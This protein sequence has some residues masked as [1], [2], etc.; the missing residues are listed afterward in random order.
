MGDG[1]DYATNFSRGNPAMANN[2]VVQSSFSGSRRERLVPL[3]ASKGVRRIFFVLLILTLLPMWFARPSHV[4][5]ATESCGLVVKIISAPFAAVDSNKPGLEGPRSA[6]LGAQ[7]LNTGGLPVKDVS[8]AFS[9]TGLTLVSNSPSSYYLNDLAPGAS[10]TAYWPVI[11]PATF[12]IS[13]P[14]QIAAS[15][16]DGCGANSSS[17]IKTQSEIGANSSKLLPTGSTKTVTPDI[18]TLG[19]LV[20]VRITGFALGTVGQGPNGTYDAWLQPVGNL[21]FDPSC[22]RLV[23]S[24]VKLASLS[25]T[26]FIDQLYF[27]GLKSYQSNLT[28]YV[29]YTFI[30]LRACSTVLQ[31]YQEAASGTQEKY[32]ADFSA[33]TSRIVVTSTN[34]STLQIAVEPD[35]TNVLGGDEIHYTVTY[36]A[37]DAPVGYPDNGNPVV[38]NAVIPDQTSYLAGSAT[39]TT[40][41]DA[42]YSTNGGSTWTTAEPVDPALVTDLRWVLT[43]P[44]DATPD[45]LQYAVT[46]DTNYT[47]ASIVTTVDSTFFDGSVLSSDSVSVAKAVG[48]SAPDAQDDSVATSRNV[49]VAITV[50]NNDT[51][52]DGNLDVASATLVD[53]PAHGDV[54]VGGNG[55][56]TYTPATDFVGPDSFTYRICDTDSACDTATVVVAVGQEQLRWESSTTYVAFEDLKNVGWSD[57]D[58]NDFIVEIEIRTGLD[59]ADRVA[60]VEINYEAL[61]RGAGYS[62]RFIHDL[63]IEGGGIAMLSVFDSAGGL[64]LQRTTEFDTNTDFTIFDRTADALPP[65]T[66]FFDTNTRTSQPSVVQGRTATLTVFLNNPDANP[67]VALPPAPWDPYLYVYYT[68]QEV[69]LVSPGHMDNTQIVNP[70]RDPSSPL[71]GYDLPLAQTF[72]AGWQW[73]EEFRGIWRGFPEF[74]DAVGSGGTTNQDWWEP[75]NSVPT[76]LWSPSGP[77]AAVADMT[78][79]VANVDTR[80]FAGPVAADLDNDGWSEVIIGNFLANQVEVTNVRGYNVTGWP[81]PVGGG[82]KSAV[83]TADLDGDGNLEILAGAGNGE[84]YAWHGNGQSLTGWPVTLHA[85]YRI[86]AKPA[87]GDLDGDGALEVIVPVSDGKLYAVDRAGNVMPGWPVSIGDVADVYGGQVINSSAVFADVDGDGAGEIIVGSTDKRLYLFNRD[88]SQRWVYPTDDMVLATPAVGDIDPTKPGQEIVVASGD[89]YIY[90]LDAAGNLI[91]RRPTGWI[92]RSS[93]LIAD[94]DSDQS[95]EIIVGSDDDKVWAW[96][97]DGSLVSGWPQATG[98][99]ILSSPVVGDIDGDGRVEI[100]VGSDDAKVWAWHTDG[101]LVDGW[102]RAAN[103]SVKGAPLLVNLDDDAAPE[104]A[105]ADLSGVIHT[106]NI[107]AVSFTMPVYLPAV[108]QAP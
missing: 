61:A 96:H 99:D 102:P 63:P 49:A 93:P 48:N 26:P 73:P 98:A 23:R 74:V 6:M 75:I 97:S 25:P 56:F 52:V 10:V 12:D 37:P 50:T 89:R 77:V 20:T 100:I 19:S 33:A 78:A 81:Q 38:I 27:V 17:Q 104:V 79:D 32:N 85:G 60:A 4:L 2:L 58:Y 86:L 46:V 8:V 40:L 9:S 80:Y 101:A 95:P 82:V 57:W 106:W 64:V 24:E 94:L 53:P 108:F 51:D 55:L 43:E 87:V 42:E 68:Q 29:A 36:V 67:A 14:Y 84:V 30:A 31:P 11:Y 69:H 15:T 90:L 16:P 35:R 39:E 71:V 103:L 105:A 5:A 107:G 41:I 34:S 66:G 91:W 54:T 7:I 72:V 1:N 45:Q 59:G 47:G 70:A 83:L 76:W 62:Q 88:G 21:D 3:S 92:I 65:L 44:V 28:D 13:Y 18:V 22:L